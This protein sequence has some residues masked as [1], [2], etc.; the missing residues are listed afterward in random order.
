[1]AGEIDL[2]SLK[3]RVAGKLMEID[4]VSGVGVGANRIHVYLTRDDDRV[5]SAV[6]GVMSEHAAE[7]PFEFITAGPF[8]KQ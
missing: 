4:G 2:E 7:A 8:L 6:A 5:R 1:M 3:G